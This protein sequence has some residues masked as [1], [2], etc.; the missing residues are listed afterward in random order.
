MSDLPS[1]ESQFN[2]R[3][4]SSGIRLPPEDIAQRRRGRLHQA[5]WTLWYLF[6]VDDRG[7]Y[8]DLYTRHRKSFDT[9]TRLRE[10]QEPEDLPAIDGFFQTSDDPA[11]ARQLAAAY[12]DA[13]QRV[14]ALLAAKGFDVQGVEPGLSM[15]IRYFHTP[16][17][18]EGGTPVVAS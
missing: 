12:Y 8:L 14:V 18:P 4:A 7:E 17:T 9:H 5:G 11:E 13:Q 16:P 1:I 2:N 3:F 6:G 15:T 10:D